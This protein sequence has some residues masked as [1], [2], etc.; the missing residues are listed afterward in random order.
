MQPGPVN[1]PIVVSGSHGE[2]HLDRSGRVLRYTDH[3]EMC[4]EEGCEGYSDV[5]RVDLA[6][7]ARWAGDDAEDRI[8][9]LEVGYWT[10]EGEY[11]AA[12]ESFRNRH[13]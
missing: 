7:Y 4:G 9:I 1:R 12:D 8:D 6:E 11:I 2:L 3:E 10:H 5:A 13:L